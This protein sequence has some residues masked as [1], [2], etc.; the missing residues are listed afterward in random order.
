VTAAGALVSLS[1]VLGVS[2]LL[3]WTGLT[4]RPGLGVLGAL[5]VVGLTL[6]LRG[7]GPAALGFAL[8]E[9]W[10]RTVLLALGLGVAVQLLSVTLV[11]P[12]AERPR[13]RG[14]SGPLPGRRP[15]TSSWGRSCSASR[16]A[17]R[18]AAAC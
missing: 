14:C 6:G 8:P 11:E 3:V 2:G 1:L 15:S 4:K 7:D 12:W 18:D 17:T 5:L 10:W 9:A 16:T 13:R